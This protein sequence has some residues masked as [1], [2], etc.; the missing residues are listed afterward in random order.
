MTGCFGDAS[1]WIALCDADDEFHEQATEYSNL[2]KLERA[3]IVTT[4]LVLNEMLN[5]RSGT[6]RAQRLAAVLM[7]DEI[8][9]NHRISVEPQSSAQF[10]EAFE[11]MRHRIDKEWSITDCASFLV[12][13]EHGITE[14][15]TSDRHFEQAGYIALLR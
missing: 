14:A 1:Y 8:N 12:M 4:Q 10:A 11:W 5:P 3:P 6:T 13:Q 7:V 2:L 9:R 15:L